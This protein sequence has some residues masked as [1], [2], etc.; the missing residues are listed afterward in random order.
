MTFITD[1]VRSQAPFP[2]P[3]II[4]VLALVLGLSTI[5][6]SA[7]MYTRFN[8]HQRLWWDDW[9]MVL[10]WL[11]TIALCAIQ[12][13]MIR[14]GSGL[15]IQDV[16]REDYKQFLDLF[17]DVQIVARVAIF[18]A[19]TSILL[20]YIR[21]FFPLGTDR[22]T[23]WWVIQV[24]IW[25]NLLYT[26]SLILVTTLQCVPYGLP[27]GST[28]VDQWLVLILAST[29]NIIS[30]IAVL[31]IPL[32]SIWKLQ[33]SQKRKWAT[34]ALFAFGALAPIASIVRLGYQIPMGNDPNRTVIY[35][36]I[37][38]FAT[39]EQ[40]VAMIIGSA[41]VC[42][43]LFVRIIRGKRSLSPRRN[44]TISQRMWPDRE[45][46]NGSVPKRTRRG[47]PDP[48]RITDVTGTTS[49]EVLYSQAHAPRSEGEHQECMELAD[50]H[51]QG[52]RQG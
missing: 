27:F 30:D 18:F 10:A 35:P 38:L 32:A 42:N 6:T 50:N 15:N 40:A 20:L 7:Q 13:L 25:A 24:T 9:S 41:P 12:F 22:S 33:M 44:V 16:P 2:A 48:F 23:F 46:K 49:T 28:C 31:V 8:V 26:I 34:W 14:H 4:A 1:Y 45:R 37:T 47:V 52:I 3:S 19:R 11:G 21:V 36:V 51:V 5:F 43:A 39:A 29:I 17:L